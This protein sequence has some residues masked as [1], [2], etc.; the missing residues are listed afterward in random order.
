MIVSLLASMLLIGTGMA[1]YTPGATAVFKVKFSDGTTFKNHTAPT[2]YDVGSKFNATVEIQD[3]SLM[4]GFTV[5]MGWNAVFLQWTGNKW[6]SAWLKGLIDAGEWTSPL[7]TIK[8]DWEIPQ[9]PNLGGVD[10]FASSALGAQYNK[11]GTFELFT[12]EFQ[13]MNYGGCGLY[14]S[15]TWEP[16]Y[17]GNQKEQLL[18]LFVPWSPSGWG[19]PTTPMGETEPYDVVWAAPGY[20]GISNLL[21]I[22]MP[23]P[24]RAP[25]A[26]KSVAPPF[27]KVGETLTVTVTQVKPGF[28]GLALCPITQVT[29]DWD[30][31][32]PTE[33]GAPSGD[34]LSIAF[35]HNYSVKGTYYLKAYC[36]AANMPLALAWHNLTNVVNVIE[37]P[38]TGIDVYQVRPEGNEGEGPDVPGRPYDPQA[39]V[40]L[41]AF[42]FYGGDAVQAKIVAFEVTV[43]LECILYRT[44]YTDENGIAS[45]QFRIPNLCWE[46]GGPD[47]LFGKWDVFVDVDIA[48]VKYN[49]TMQFDVGYIITL[50]NMV[51]VKSCTEPTAE[52]MFKKAEYVSFN[53]T[54]TN[55]D[56][57]YISAV[58]ILVVYDENQVP[59]GQEIIQ[60]SVA[61]GEFCSPYVT[62]ICI[63]LLIP[64]YAYVGAGTGYINAFTAIPSECGLPWC[65][66]VSDS[67][68]IQKAAP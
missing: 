68:L 26:T 59:I 5:T 36:F 4:T 39:L 9:V 40:T 48:Q 42:V 27:P 29:I 22:V 49:D 52:E 44:D 55:I 33:S 63:S 51:S 24:P 31:G 3:V 19:T 50:S 35:T 45:I 14:I 66:E 25:E 60:Q 6:N 56:W 1:Q 15:K 41:E 47:E 64:K 37:V 20:L 2:P 65:P 38:K 67:F 11:T 28:N 34:P 13:V 61:N 7:G 18:H 30:D 8:N 17:P 21:L 12:L 53:V 46:Y 62:T 57:K 32:S 43:G 58:I 10:G 54:I 23:P 16:A